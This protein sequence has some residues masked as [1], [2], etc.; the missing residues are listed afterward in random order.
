MEG[1]PAGARYSMSKSGWMDGDNLVWFGSALVPAV[2]HLLTS[3]SVV[4][5]V[6]GHHSYLLLS[7]V[8]MAYEKGVNIF[9]LPPHTT[10]ILQP[11]DM[12]VY[13]PLTQTWKWDTNY[14]Q[15]MSVKRTFQVSQS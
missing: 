3:G 14:W 2:G 11:L 13:G 15:Q 5:F 9:C 10:H 4:L 12:K 1:G 7:V 6:D 8:K